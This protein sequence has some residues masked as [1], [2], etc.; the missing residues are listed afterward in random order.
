MATKKGPSWHRGTNIEITVTQMTWLLI[1]MPSRKDLDQEGKMWKFI[2]EILFKR[3]RKLW[4]E[5]SHTHSPVIAYRTSKKKE[6]ASLPQWQCTNH[7]PKPMRNCH[8]L[9]PLVSF[10]EILFKTTLPSF[11]PKPN[12]SWP[13][14][15]LFRL[16]CGSPQS[17]CPEF[18]FLCYSQINSTLIL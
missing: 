16:A 8:H 11:L 15:C 3:V 13:S 2:R 4:G 6:D 5:S 14:L 7:S 18:Q 10:R 12:K 1:G 9:G 17:A